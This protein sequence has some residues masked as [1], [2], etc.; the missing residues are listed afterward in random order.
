M[1]YSWFVDTYRTLI[2][3]WAV[4]GD[5]FWHKN[6]H[7]FYKLIWALD[8][9]WGSLWGLPSWSLFGYDSL[10]FIDPWSKTWYIKMTLKGPW[11]IN[12]ELRDW[13]GKYF[14]S[15]LCFS[16]LIVPKNDRNIGIFFEKVIAS[17]L[18]CGSELNWKLKQLNSNSDW[19][20]RCR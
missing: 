9:A 16:S 6:I 2:R 8:E 17:T 10:T 3:I 18:N 11:H 14:Y 19:N 12:Q 13:Y 4:L 7:I 1:T 15:F 5:F 20:C